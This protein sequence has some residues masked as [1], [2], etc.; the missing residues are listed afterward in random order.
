MTPQEAAIPRPQRGGSAPGA[1]SS[2]YNE[3]RR[4]EGHHP[5]PT[6]RPERSRRAIRR[7]QRSRR[8]PGRPEAP[9]D[10]T[11]MYLGTLT[12][13]EAPRD[14][15]HV[16]RRREARQTS[17]TVVSGA[18]W[19]MHAFALFQKKLTFFRHLD[20]PLAGNRITPNAFGQFLG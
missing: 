9:R 18:P 12:P 19:K 13:L 10:L 5:S 2:V 7:P 14:R 4:P 1:P 17:A 3:L 16:F 15:I 11:Y 6:P 8:A 20:V